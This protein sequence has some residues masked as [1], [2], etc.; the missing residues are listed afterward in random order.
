MTNT[1][2]DLNTT[3][4]TEDLSMDMATYKKVKGTMDPKT[5]V[6]ITGD[7]APLKPI[8]SSPTTST[9]NTTMSEDIIE[10]KDKA[11]IKY[12]SNV[13]DAKTGDISKPFSIGGKKYQLVRGTNL[14]NE[15]VMGVYSHDDKDDNGNNVIHEM[16][17]F[18]Q[19]IAIPMKEK[20]EL[21]STSRPKEQTFI[22]KPIETESKTKSLGLGEYKHFIVNE[23]G[24]FRKFKELP[25]LASANM[26]EGEKYMGAKQFKQYFE[27][28]VFGPSKRNG[29]MELNE[30]EPIG[31]GDDD[32]N[33]HLKAE[34]LMNLIKTKISPQILSTINT[35]QARR[36][37]IAAFGELLGVQRTDLAS[38]INS[39]KDIT[40]VDAVS[41][42]RIIKTIKIKDIK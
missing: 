32:A 33:L 38:L 28:T 5:P 31:A 41:E 20:I 23:K 11:T 40:S 4:I 1:N 25:E 26:G 34:K 30:L 22:S 35:P 10:P 12:L 7:K 6:T 42:S 17:A 9:S 19:N 2:K 36:E 15:V 8:T 14:K 21:E 29:K 37:V 3:E 18:E 27:E 16:N 39:L 13:R 24:G